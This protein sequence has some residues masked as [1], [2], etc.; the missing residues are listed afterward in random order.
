MKS[1]VV[2]RR[3]VNLDM[4]PKAGVDLD[5][6]RNGHEGSDEYG[7]GELDDHIKTLLLPTGCE[8]GA[9][10]APAARGYAGLHEFLGGSFGPTVSFIR[11]GHEH[12]DH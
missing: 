10:S 4:T 9:P 12:H 1:N 5:Q 6:E 2:T 7:T 3:L 11:A 8:P